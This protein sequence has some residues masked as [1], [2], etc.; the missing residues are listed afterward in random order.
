MM[1][2]H[3]ES[4]CI[5]FLLSLLITDLLFLEDPYIPADKDITPSPTPRIHVDI[6][7]KTVP[8]N[9]QTPRT[10]VIMNPKDENRP[11][12]F[13]AQP[14]ILAGMICVFKTINYY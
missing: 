1:K 9:H 7:T 13:F 6:T 4:V 5:T 10:D 8:V 11:T 3:Q 12:S 14:G 2:T